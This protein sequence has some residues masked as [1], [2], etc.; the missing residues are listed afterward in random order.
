M[1]NANV[2][3]RFADYLDR[4]AKEREAKSTAYPSLNFA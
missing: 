2:G 1:K 3:R 4:L